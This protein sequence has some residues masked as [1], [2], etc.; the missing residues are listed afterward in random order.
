MVKKRVG[1]L[2]G[3][4]IQSQ[5]EI[6]LRAP[7]IKV[8]ETDS[9][10]SVITSMISQK[11]G[12]MLISDGSS[13]ITGI[14]TEQDVVR[15]VFGKVSDLAK[16]PISSVMT[17]NPQSLKYNSSIGR[18]LHLMAVGGFRHIPVQQRDGSWSVVSVRDFIKFLYEKLQARKEREERGLKIFK[19]E[20][21]VEAFLS[22]LVSTIDTPPA[23]T[24]PEDTPTADAV[25]FMSRN[26]AS[27]L[28]ITTEDPKRIRGVFSERDLLNKVVLQE[29][30]AASSPISTFMTRDPVTFL[31]DTSVLHALRT[32]NERAF[33]HVPLVDFEEQLL[34]ILSVQDFVR[35]LAE[36]VVHTLSDK[37]LKKQAL[38]ADESHSSLHQEE[39]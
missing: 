24:V 1:L 20:N 16:T 17:R 22:G 10:L 39:D 32:M 2:E 26:S 29:N 23:I 14:F 19:E 11:V 36:E 28:V 21:E 33:R 7:A 12:C 8:A 9:L 13:S 4:F 5:L 35:A 38:Q 25:K 30:E 18:A 15:R 27:C 37:S 31:P 34:G 6:L 3:A